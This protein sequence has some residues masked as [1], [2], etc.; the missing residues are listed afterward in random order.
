MRSA[1]GR[2]FSL[3][4]RI[5]IPI[6]VIL[7]S[8]GSITQLRSYVDASTRST[9]CTF[10]QGL[11]ICPIFRRSGSKRRAES[12]VE[13]REIAEARVQGDVQHRLGGG[14]ESQRRF[15]KPSS[16]KELMGREADDL[17]E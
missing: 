17:L 13:I 15:T 11:F 10:N 12:V 4:G 6:A 2:S 3:N 9:I 5:V 16:Q 14:S 8:F 7:R 1:S